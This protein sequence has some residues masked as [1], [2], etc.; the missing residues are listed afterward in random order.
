LKTYSG[1]AEFRM[2]TQR[3]EDF[4]RARVP[5]NHR[6]GRQHL[7][8]QYLKALDCDSVSPFTK[9]I[10]IMSHRGEIR[11]EDQNRSIRRIR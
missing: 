5:I 9:A 7:L 10:E 3:A 2:Q 6:I 11:V 4:I 1:S 8:Q